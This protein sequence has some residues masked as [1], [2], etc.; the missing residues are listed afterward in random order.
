M[1]QKQYKEGILQQKMAYI[2]KEERAS[3]NNLCIYL[4]KPEKE[5]TKPKIRRKI[6]SRSKQNEEQKLG[7]GVL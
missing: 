5:E 4:E 1:Q 6:K 2:N 3:I 7:I